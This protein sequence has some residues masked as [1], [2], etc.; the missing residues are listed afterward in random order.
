VLLLWP[1]YIWVCQ[2]LYM[3][4]PIPAVAGMYDKAFDGAYQIL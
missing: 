1:F 2:E 3:K 4:T